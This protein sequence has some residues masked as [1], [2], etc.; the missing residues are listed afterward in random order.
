[1]II[2]AD[3]RGRH[4]RMTSINPA[5]LIQHALTSI[6]YSTAKQAVVIIVFLL[7]VAAHL[8]I[9]ITTLTFPCDYILKTSETLPHSIIK[10]YIIVL[11]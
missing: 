4:A 1:V 9:L 5:L 10:I 11:T 8:L 6:S 3:D 7:V 2:V